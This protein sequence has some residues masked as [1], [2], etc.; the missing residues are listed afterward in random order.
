MA[1]GVTTFSGTE[2]WWQIVVQPSDS[3]AVSQAIPT[4]E[5]TLV[6]EV[7]VATGSPPTGATTL[8]I[9]TAADP[10]AI[11]DNYDLDALTADSQATMTI[12]STNAVIP[13]G[14][15][16]TIDIGQATTTAGDGVTIMFKVRRTSLADTLNV[17]DP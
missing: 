2:E 10:D 12:A 4:F 5:D 8:D 16:I 14:T 1:R 17:N 6:K 15:P 11:V 3:A 9:G 7:R 13:A